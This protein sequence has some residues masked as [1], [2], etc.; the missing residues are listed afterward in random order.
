MV[1]AFEGNRA[2]TT[3]MLPLIR[4]F[5]KA[6]QLADVTIVADAGMVSLMRTNA[7]WGPRACHSSSEQ[8]SPRPL[9]W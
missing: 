2:E 6:Q 5:M 9:T 3:T 7:L 4:E 8:V 1:N